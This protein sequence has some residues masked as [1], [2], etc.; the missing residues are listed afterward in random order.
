MP[1]FS[2][3]LHS[4]LRPYVTSCVGYDYVLDD[5]HATHHGLPSTGLTV[6]LSF[7]EPL[8][9]GWLDTADTRRHWTMVAG[10]HDRPAL[11][12]THGVQ[13]GMQLQLTPTGARRIL[14][15]PAGQLARTI[16]QHDDVGAAFDDALHRQ[17]ADVDWGSRFDLLE[18]H[19]LRRLTATE[20]SSSS[21]ELSAVWTMITTHHGAYRIDRIADDVG[22]SRRHLRNRFI[23]EF[24]LSPKRLSL[25][26]RF[27]RAH[28]L[29]TDGMPLATV[30]HTTGYT[31]Q[32]HLNR[33][34]RAFAG[35]TPRETLGEFPSVQEP[36]P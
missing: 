4:A 12:R 19:L 17:L 31:D 30:A 18:R 23:D 28:Q 32:A 15:L 26:A 35:Q 21:P 1:T 5:P 33:D 16:A 27:D 25:L 22:W 10:I 9:C 29:A 13:C 14:G 3:P 11:I 6:V 2:R 7:P 8:D 34:W 20:R 36:L 24:G